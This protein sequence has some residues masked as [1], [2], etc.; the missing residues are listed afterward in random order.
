MSNF[1]EELKRRKV[2]RVSATYG[3]VAWVI[4][5]IGEVTF[6]ALHL[7]DWVLTA[8]VVI[9]LIGFPIVTIIAWIFDKTPEG[10]VRTEA[11]K[12]SEEI[13]PVTKI[14]NMKVKLDNRPFYLQKRNIFLV[15]GV[16]AGIVIGQLNL[17]KSK[18]KLANYT[19]DRIP[20][21]IADFKNQTNDA[22]LDGLSGLLI[23]SL[24]QSNYLS[25][26]TRSRMFDLLK[27]IGKSNVNTV[28]E[29]L[30]VEIC[31]RA[32]INA[33][34]LTSIRQFGDLYSVDLKILDVEKN[35]YLYTTNV[36]AEG[37]KNI[38]AL[39][40]KI[41]KQTRLSLAE[42]AEEVEKNQRQIA[43][44]TTKN[45]EAY[46]YYD[47]GT[48]AMY[49]NDF[50]LA[51]EN[52][53]KAID[54]DSTFSLALYQLAYANQWYFRTEEANRYIKEAVKYIDSVPEK[55]RLYI[56][57][58]SIKDFSSRIPIY[59][60]IVN[61]YPN[62]KLAYF[63][64]GDMLYHNGPV[65]QSIP[66][67][68]KSLSLDPSF[69]FSIQHLG[70]AYRDVGLHDKD[71]ELTSQSLKIYPDKN[72]Y[73]YRE[74]YS[75]LYAGRVDEFFSK[76]RLL[77]DKDIQFTSTDVA[78]GDAYLFKGDYES[79]KKSYSN[80]LNT[81]ET[82][83]EG[84][85]KLQMLSLYRGNLNRFISLSDE[86]LNINISKNNTV[87]YLNELSH[88]AY[89]LLVI[90]NKKAEAKKIILEIEKEI[91]DESK[92]IDYSNLSIWSRLYLI[93]TYK[94]FKMWT[95]GNDLNESAFGN[96]EVIL[97]A[98]KGLKSKQEGAFL[99][100]IKYY[101][102]AL[103]LGNSFHSYNYN[104]AIGQCYME[105]NDY[106]NA[107]KHFDN[108]KGI[109]YYGQGHA[110]RYYHARNFLYSGL[111]NMELK[112]YRLAKS[113]I[114]TFLKIWQPAPESLKEKKMAREALK[115]I[116]KATS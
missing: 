87:A 63:E 30:G 5:Q 44:L 32:D 108:M 57:A 46:K 105:I 68:E 98:D 56:R 36:Q 4:M 18:E 110:K 77:D 97:M 11:S 71:I 113:N 70:W 14:G 31:E 85:K 13:E 42:R 55:E 33:L 94:L 104:F 27:Q 90:F 93:D 26:L 16:V 41:S 89:S 82:K 114:E 84:I 99:E 8:V 35:E 17:F 38:P 58:Q 92:N 37:K 86:V 106:Q 29:E 109:S 64:I 6:P 12:Q 116:N 112:N 1:L 69:E 23:T 107:I 47:L 28:D 73:K 61:K 24:E 7:P 3:V 51:I 15:L 62:E 91:S 40:D 111:A 20:V 39:I 101:S 60:E 78:F 80:L 54:I 34:V 53:E 100:A 96:L 66:Y 21:A 50:P 2:F 48:K 83:L 43:S 25:V 88:R 79:A 75:Y 22:S 76:V 72:N 19:G 52:F 67:F 81:S 95:K 9:L 102:Q 49:S 59:E 45:L 115:K 74:L 103:E 10:I 65:P